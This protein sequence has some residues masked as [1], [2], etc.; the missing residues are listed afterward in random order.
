MVG[1]V[2][3]RRQTHHHSHVRGQFKD[4]NDKNMGNLFTECLLYY[5][6]Q[7]ALIT[8]ARIL[9]SLLFLKI[10]FVYICSTL[11]FLLKQEGAEYL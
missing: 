10:P 4:R 3:S 2:H 5:L 7:M 11:K 6:D 9:A 1:S 8:L